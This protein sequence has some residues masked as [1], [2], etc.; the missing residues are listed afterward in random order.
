VLAF[1][2]VMVGQN[3]VQG[4][5]REFREN[6]VTGVASRALDVF[7]LTKPRVHRSDRYMDASLPGLDR[8]S[9]GSHHLLVV[10]VHFA[11]LHMSS[12]YV[13]IIQTGDAFVWRKTGDGLS[14]I[15]RTLGL[16]LDCPQIVRT[17]SLLLSVFDCP[18]RSKDTPPLKTSRASGIDIQ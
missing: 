1:V 18:G 15:V 3:I 12:T 7:N 5:L 13:G 17:L 16:S 14:G 8:H 6:E 9:A 10:F 2:G 4:W 11:C